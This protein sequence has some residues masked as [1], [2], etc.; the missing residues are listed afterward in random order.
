MTITN[1]ST[2]ELQCYENRR[3]KKISM[4]HTAFTKKA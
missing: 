1:K 4:M 3:G 2:K